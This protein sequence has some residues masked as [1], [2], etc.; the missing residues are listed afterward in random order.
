MS[1]LDGPPVWREVFRVRAGEIGPGGTLRLPSL[2][3]YLQEAAGNHAVALGYGSDELLAR[4]QTWILSRLKLE[5]RA[6]PAWRQEVAVETWPTGVRRL[7][8]LRE[9]RLTDAAGGTLALATSGWLILKVASKRPIRP[10]EEVVAFAARTPP[11]AL[12]DPFEDLAGP[13]ATASTGP[14]FRV[15]RYDLDLNGHANN[16]SILRWL[17]ESLPV[18]PTP[19]LSLEVEYRGECFEGDVLAAR[20]EEESPGVTRHALVRDADGREV[21][22]AVTTVTPRAPL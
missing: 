19:P 17:V 13:S 11:R 7:W 12:D 18:P 8:A 9:F 5:V 4:G 21:A 1:A 3:D 16:V 22:R 2:G 14:S 10:P 15:G 6:L 20:L